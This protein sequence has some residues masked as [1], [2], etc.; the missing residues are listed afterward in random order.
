[1]TPRAGGE[2]NYVVTYPECFALETLPFKELPRL[3]R[4]QW[5]V[6]HNI[7]NIKFHMSDGNSSPD[8]GNEYLVEKDHHFGDNIIGMIEIQ[9]IEKEDAICRLEFFDREGL[10]LLLIKGSPALK[11]DVH[12]TIIGPD[13]KLCGFRIN[14]KRP[15]V[16]GMEFNIAKAATGSEYEAKALSMEYD[17]SRN[18]QRFDPVKLKV[19]PDV[20]P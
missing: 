18:L 8:L 4:V 19:I 10:S 12:T 2:T 6:R 20:V 16:I 14:H 3:V 1:M 5:H 9:E 7:C 11:V 17:S 13:E 15:L